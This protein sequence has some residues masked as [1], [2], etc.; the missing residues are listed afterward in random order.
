LALS[1]F[2]EKAFRLSLIVRN[3]DRDTIAECWDR[4]VMIQGKHRNIILAVIV[5]HSGEKAK[6]DATDR[7]G[8]G[9][10]RM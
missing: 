3:S 10:E 1:I 7:E 6:A 5:V 9:T 2:A 8:N 4:Y